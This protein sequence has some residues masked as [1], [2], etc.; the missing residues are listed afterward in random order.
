[1]T[2][3]VIRPIERADL[4]AVIAILQAGSLTPSDEDPEDLDA[5]WRAVDS[6]RLANGDVLIAASD[7]EVIGVCQVVTIAHL[8]HRGGWCAEVESLHVR[9]DMR[10]RGV[11]AALL[12]AAETFAAE[13]GCYRVQLTSDARRVDAHRFYRANGYADSHVGFKRAL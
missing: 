4:A 7:E 12:G 8:R 10:S 13:H 11:G 9:A 1:M 6:I 5:Y 3:W 2:T